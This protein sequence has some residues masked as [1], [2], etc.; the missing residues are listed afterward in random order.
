MDSP[1]GKGKQTPFRKERIIKEDGRYLIYYWFNPP[2]ESDEKL[3]SL[4][5][6]DA[7]GQKARFPSKDGVGQ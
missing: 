2:K 6:E 4:H 7:A 1:D 5:P 3:N